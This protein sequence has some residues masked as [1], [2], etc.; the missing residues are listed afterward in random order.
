[1][2][3]L[4]ALSF[5]LLAT[6]ACGT[7]GSSFEVA[8]TPLAGTVGG[9][10]WTF[11]AGETDAFLSNGETDFFAELRPAAY[12]TCTGAP[13]SGNHLIVSIPKAVGDYDM[14]PQLNMTFVVGSDNKIAFDGRIIVTEVT[15]TKV[16]GGLHASF[17][18]SN[19]V[20]GQFDVAICPP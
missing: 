19:E 8:A 2:I 11:V 7:D 10:A 12:T 1:M 20:D 4:A 16:K 15:A 17:D 14:G 5:A 3:K 9:Q 6:A 18:G 13:P